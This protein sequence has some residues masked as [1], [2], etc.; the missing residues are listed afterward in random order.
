MKFYMTG[1]EGWSLNTAGDCLI[2]VTTWAGLIING[3]TVF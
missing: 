3:V 2:E 1:Q